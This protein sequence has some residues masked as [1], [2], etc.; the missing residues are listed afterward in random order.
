MWQGVCSRHEKAGGDAG[1]Q[2]VMLILRERQWTR[3]IP[4]KPRLGIKKRQG[5]AGGGRKSLLLGRRIED[6]GKPWEKKDREKH[7]RRRGANRLEGKYSCAK[8]K[9]RRPADVREAS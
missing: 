3:E 9:T 6:D 8:V 7:K 5:R 4:P 1:S 2:E